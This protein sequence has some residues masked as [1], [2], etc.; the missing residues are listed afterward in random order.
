MDDGFLLCVNSETECLLVRTDALGIETRRVNLKES[1]DEKIIDVYAD[2]FSAAQDTE[3]FHAVVEYA[4][5]NTGYKELRIHALTEKLEE[6]YKRWFSRSQS[7]EY[8][9]G[10]AHLNGFYLLANLKGL[11]TSVLTYYNWR[12]NS[13][14]D[15]DFDN[16]TIPLIQ[17]YTCETVIPT[18]LGRYAALIKAAD[19]VPYL[20]DCYQDFKRHSI[21]ELGAAPAE[22][23]RLLADADTFYA[24][25]YRLGDISAMYRF[26]ETITVRDEVAAFKK[27]SD[28][29]CHTITQRGTLFCGRTSNKI[30]VAGINKNGVAFESAFNS[31]NETVRVCIETTGGL[32]L[33]GESASE[34]YNAGA[35]FGGTDIWASKLLF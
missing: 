3:P 9:A 33:I 16:L 34:G 21:H 28:L 7:L 31:Q 2:F 19:N 22:K 30:I 8:V 10:Y 26:D 13:S 5:P 20:I 17:R 1:K 24:Y 25:V 14:S 29:F 4:N 12:K 11:N 18:H 27:F 6:R 35:N 32:I 15:A 23:T